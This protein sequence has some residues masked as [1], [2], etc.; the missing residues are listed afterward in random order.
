MLNAGNQNWSEEETQGPFFYSNNFGELTLEPVTPFMPISEICSKTI[1]EI[2]DVL[3]SL[4]CAEQATLITENKGFAMSVV[5]PL[6]EST[7]NFSFAIKYSSARR[8]AVCRV[9]INR[10]HTKSGLTAQEQIESMALK[11][12]GPIPTF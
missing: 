6:P 3:V 9:T 1:R 8:G 12:I 10:F 5:F 4:D 11:T 7:E 2:H